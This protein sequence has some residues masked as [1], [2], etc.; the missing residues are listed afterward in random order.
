MY[1]SLR[2]EGCLGR[3]RW[4]NG[5]GSMVIGVLVA[6][7]LMVPKF[8]GPVAFAAGVVVLVGLVRYMTSNV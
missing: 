2:S 8:W 6:A 7:G 1:G 3:F 4:D 5:G